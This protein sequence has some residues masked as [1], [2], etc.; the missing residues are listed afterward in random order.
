MITNE[1]MN[2][3]GL[4]R[5]IRKGLRTRILVVYGIY[6]GFILGVCVLLFGC[7]AGPGVQRGGSATLGP[8]FVQQPDNPSGQAVQERTVTAV[9]EWVPPAQPSATPHHPPPPPTLSPRPPSAPVVP[10]ASVPP[11]AVASP[12][13]ATGAMAGGVIRQTYSEHTRQ[14]VGSSH[15][16]TARELAARAASLRPAQYVGFALLLAS[17][18]MFHPLV[19]RV[20]GSR[21]TQA[22]CGL[23]GIL[24]ILSPSVV[25][26]HE[27]LL[28]LAGLGVIAVWW[29]G[30]RHGELRGTTRKSDP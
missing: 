24:L 18:A 11:P 6:L 22:A 23:V 8:A 4:P 15:K 25:P 19:A 30:H 13:P 16:D 14:E 28:I 7:S 12:I 1:E 26:G 17:L 27:R 21:T 29:F 5:R 20:V 3:L 2:L 10:T 9:T